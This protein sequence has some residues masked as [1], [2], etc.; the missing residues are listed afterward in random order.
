MLKLL[1]RSLAVIVF[2]GF[3]CAFQDVGGR[4]LVRLSGWQ[5][6]PAL[7][8]L[9]FLALAV[10]FG[11]TALFGRFYCSVFC[12]LGILQDAIAALASLCGVKVQREYSRAGS[13]LRWIVLGLSSVCV[14]FGVVAIPALIF[15][16]S[17]FG[18]IATALF[19]PVATFAMNLT[20]SLFDALDMPILM[21]QE[22]F[23]KGAMA[24]FV[25]AATL[26]ALGGVTVW[27]GRWFCNALCPAGTLLGACA[28]RPL[29]R[30]K[31]DPTAC[32]K[33]GICE[34]QC[35][36]RCIDSRNA[37]IDNA[38]CVRC[39]NCIYACAKGAIKW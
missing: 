17:A 38:R 15:P 37:V 13:K 20:A 28:T 32:V 33:C 9:D 35:K 5:V 39:M 25:A 26:V 16:Y 2:I 7:L 18:R 22:I 30:L 11:L 6:I 19:V 21:K 23:I 14:V 31:I 36:A 10:V 29:F 34:K 1:R 12:P 8:A 4:A 3:L 27:K 24:L